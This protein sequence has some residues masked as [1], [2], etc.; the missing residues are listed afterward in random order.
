MPLDTITI[1][2]FFLV[3][4]RCSGMLIAAPVFGAA[5]L[6]VMIRVFITL[7]LSMALTFAVRPNQG[8]VPQDL[9]SFALAIGNEAV[10]GLLIGAFFSLVL[11]AVSMAGAIVD[12]QMGLGMSQV[13]NPVTGVPVSV[14]GQ[15]KYMLGLIVFLQIDAHHLMLG[16]FLQS[17]SDL[18][19]MSS[20]MME[21]MRESFVAMLTSMT[22]LA[23][24]MAAPVAAVSIVVDAALGLVNRAVP[25]M[26]VFLVGMP[27]KT[28]MGMIALAISIPALVGT[29]QT[30]VEVATDGLMLAFREAP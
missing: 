27:A 11:H 14:I 21:P 29:V 9:G 20:A 3:F 13:L 28:I 6:P 30:G 25:Q 18:P 19:T 22:Y 26:Q 23:L 2:T 16:A 24:Q 7:A 4:V 8:A 12:L 1:Y 10:S 5:N 15:F 17:Y